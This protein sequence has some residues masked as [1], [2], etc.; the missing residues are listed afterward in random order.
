VALLAGKA[1]YW[2]RGDYLARRN[3]EAITAGFPADRPVMAE[4]RCGQPVAPEHINEV[5]TE[6]ATAIVV[7]ACGGV[8]VGNATIAHFPPF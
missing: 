8:I 1:T 5:W 3:P 4:H 6:V 7:R 2:L